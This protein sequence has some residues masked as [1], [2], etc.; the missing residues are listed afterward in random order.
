MGVKKFKLEE[1]EVL[2]IKKIGNFYYAY[3]REGGS[4]TWRY[5]KERYLGCCNSDG[6][7]VKSLKTRSFK[8]LVPMIKGGK[9]I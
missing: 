4:D 2:R 1:N 6:S 5:R 9:E 3:A 7:P 8:E